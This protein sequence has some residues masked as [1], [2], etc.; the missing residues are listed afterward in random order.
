MCVGRRHRGTSLKKGGGVMMRIA[1]K[2]VEVLAVAAGGMGV[3]GMRPVVGGAEPVSVQWLEKG[4]PGISTGVTWGVSFPRGAVKKG[5]GFVMKG[6]DG[7]G[8]ALQA[9]PLGYWPDG[10]I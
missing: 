3:G 5:E 10:S 6:S 1:A 7:K 4:G 9:W 2:W 8:M